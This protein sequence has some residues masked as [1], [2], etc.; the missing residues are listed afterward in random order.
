MMD[1]KTY[2]LKWIEL[3]NKM[4]KENFTWATLE[5]NDDWH[6]YMS[7]DLYKMKRSQW[8]A[9]MTATKK[10]TNI[11]QKT[12]AAI[13]HTPE[14][15]SKLGLPTSTW[16]ATRVWSDLFSYFT[17]F[18]LIVNGDDIK[19]IEVNSD[20]PTG[21]LETSVA[22]R[23]ICEE[24]GYTSP[25]KLEENITKAW[26]KIIDA[27]NIKENDVIYFTSYGWHDEDRETTLFNLKH[28][29][30]PNKRYIA[31]EDIIVAD[32]GI[33]DEDGNKI[34]YLYRLYPLEFLDEDKDEK[35]KPIGHMFLN[36]IASGALKVINP[37]SAFVMQSKAVMAIIWSFYED[38]RLDLF[39][40]EELNNIYTYFLPT[41]FENRFHN[42]KYVSKPI[43]GRE[44]GG[45]KIFDETNKIIEQDEEDWY[46]EWSKV[47]QKYVEMPEYTLQTWDG[48]YTG[49][50]LVGSFLIG[51]EPSGLFLR[52]GTR[53]TGNLSMFCGI[54]V[55]D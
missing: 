7:F 50:L 43:L 11:L 18:D 32:D 41:Y 20:T 31:V 25:N 14:L 42:E 33:Y 26:R 37:P 28:C 24:H 34:E 55:V 9:I 13:Y 10:I 52:V 49:K 35:G 4:Q 38:K 1:Q 39:T 16:E 36:H 3:N 44:G 17:R 40:E 22:N 53:I 19:I 54:T 8:D 15:F 6:Q 21:Y 45:V 30:H 29:P 5:E 27:Y 12:Y 47:Y 48:P 2:M 46:S 51:G 23:I